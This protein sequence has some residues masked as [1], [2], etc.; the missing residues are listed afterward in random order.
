M[1]HTCWFG[2][3]TCPEERPHFVVTLGVAKPAPP[4]YTGFRRRGSKDSST[5]TSLFSQ[6]SAPIALASLS[7]TAVLFGCTNTHHQ[8]RV[9]C[10]PLGTTAKSTFYPGWTTGR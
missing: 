3:A 2:Q 6:V 8:P 10:H 9:T 5:N 1:L 7:T 4:L